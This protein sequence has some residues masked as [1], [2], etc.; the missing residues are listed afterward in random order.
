MTLALGRHLDATPGAT[1]ARATVSRNVL[2]IIG[3]LLF[4]DG[5]L[6]AHVKGAVVAYEPDRETSHV[7]VPGV[8]ITRWTCGE[9]DETGTIITARGPLHGTWRPLTPPGSWKKKDKP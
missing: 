5:S 3:T 7:S 2:P 9:T 6:R 1:P 4:G 8:A